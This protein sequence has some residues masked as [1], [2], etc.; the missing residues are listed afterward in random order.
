MFAIELLDSFAR[1][2]WTFL[3]K[4]SGK[5]ITVAGVGMDLSPH[6]N[7]RRSRLPE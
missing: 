3:S 2:R 6:K 7:A 5:V 1:R 4:S